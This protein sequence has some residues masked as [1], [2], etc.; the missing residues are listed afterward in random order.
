[1]AALVS[2]AGY[3]LFALQPASTSLPG[4]Q[5]IFKPGFF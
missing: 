5:T 2:Q 4:N 1:M 3:I